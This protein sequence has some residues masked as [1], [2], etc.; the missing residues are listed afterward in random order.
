[1]KMTNSALQAFRTVR[2]V[3]LD[4]MMRAPA[5]RHG[6]NLGLAYYTY[7]SIRRAHG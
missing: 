2:S 6:F 1:M 4:T 3:Q 7:R 5:Y